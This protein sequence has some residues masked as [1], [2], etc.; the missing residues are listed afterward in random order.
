MNEKKVLVYSWGA[1]FTSFITNT[2]GKSQK[3]SFW[4]VVKRFFEPIKVAK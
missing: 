3:M 4:Q 1:I 2:M